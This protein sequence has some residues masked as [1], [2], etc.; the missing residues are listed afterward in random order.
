[1][2]RLLDGNTEKDEPVDGTAT[3]T[4]SGHAIAVG[5]RAHMVN[6]EAVVK[7]SRL[8]SSLTRI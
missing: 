5:S 7:V 4:S 6:T 1:M 2:D 3:R 8:C